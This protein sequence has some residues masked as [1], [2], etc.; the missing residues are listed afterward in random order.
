[1][2]IWFDYTTSLRA[3]GVS[4]IGRVEWNVG[5]ALCRVRPDVRAVSVQT[6][7]LIPVTD[8]EIAASRVVNWAEPP[9]TASPRRVPAAIRQLINKHA[10]PAAPLL[11]EAGVL[12]YRGINKIHRVARRFAERAT[13]DPASAVSQV[14]L[15]CG[16]VIVSLGADWSGETVRALGQMSRAAG[17]K[18]VTMVYDL[19]PVCQPHLAFVHAPDLFREYYRTLA[20]NSDLITCIS[21]QTAAD[22]MDFAERESFTLPDVRVLTLGDSDPD[23]DSVGVAADR[24]PFFLW[25][26]TI[27]RRK[28]FELLYDALC[29]L[30][31]RGES[32]P[33][34]VI[35]GAE[36]WGTGEILRQIK[37]QSTAA[38]RACVFLGPVTNDVLYALY[39]RASA[40]LFPSLYEGWGLPLR[41]AAIRGCPVAAGD[42]PAAREALDGYDA[43]DFLSL[44]DPTAWADYIRQ[45]RRQATPL[46]P[47]SWTECAD[48]LSTMLGELV[49]RRSSSPLGP[50]SDR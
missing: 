8:D 9:P 28:N 3:T 36:G 32:L 20:S 4:G 29:Y 37:L 31:S 46:A 26:G 25:V 6:G 41:E 22:L 15:E 19:I 7:T 21:R 42:Q 49:T 5:A 33:R 1:M 23:D 16:D 24:D 18:L 27:E 43:A 50:F 47:R 14:A 39:A 11:V 13:P 35:V 48:D 10:G 40:L 45:P 17:C 38:S 12:A 30:E 2:T 34:L 44:T